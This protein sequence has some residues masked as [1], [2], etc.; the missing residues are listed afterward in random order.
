[1]RACLGFTCGGSGGTLA[2][3]TMSITIGRFADKLDNYTVKVRN[4]RELVGEIYFNQSSE[5]A[6]DVFRAVEEKV[7][8]GVSIG[9]IPVKMEKR[10][11]RGRIF[12]SGRMVEGSVLTLGDNPNA[13]PTM[14][15]ILGGKPV[16]VWPKEAALQKF[17]F[18][19]PKA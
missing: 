1:M 19:R 3:A 16:A 17:V 10:H 18:P 14:I 15:Q 11:D 12:H 8:S 5:F 7:F 9:F 13:I 6:H 2:S 4:G